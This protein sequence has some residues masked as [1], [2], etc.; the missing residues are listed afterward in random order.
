MYNY[1][2]QSFS[3]PEC[4]EEDEAKLRAR[5]DIMRGTDQAFKDCVDKV[6]PE[7]VTIVSSFKGLE[8]LDKVSCLL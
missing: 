4:S 7:V 1:R 6:R 3:N 8:P 2:C 5:C